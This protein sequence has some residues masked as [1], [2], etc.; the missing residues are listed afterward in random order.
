[1]RPPVY[2]LAP[3]TVTPEA[4]VPVKAALLSWPTAPPVYWAPVTAVRRTAEFF[5]AAAA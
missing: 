1:M 2:W 4:Y 3:W 5:T